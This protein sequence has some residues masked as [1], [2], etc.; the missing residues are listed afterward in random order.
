[1]TGR[2]LDAIEVA[3]YKYGDS[4]FD[5]GI[6]SSQSVSILSGIYGISYKHTYNAPSIS[7]IEANLRYKYPIYG[8]F[9]FIGNNEE[10]KGHATVIYRYLGYADGSQADK[11]GV[12]DPEFGF[13]TATYT[14]SGFQYISAYSGV[15]LTLASAA[16]M[17]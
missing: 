8:G 13:A 12:M 2:N 4:D 16:R 6:Y 5:Y 9:K 17:Y 1:M 11:I 14:S 3:K 10:L 7:T 15:T